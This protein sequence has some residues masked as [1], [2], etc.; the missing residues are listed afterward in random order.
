MGFVMRIPQIVRWTRPDVFSRLLYVAF[1]MCPWTRGRTSFSVMSVENMS[2]LLFQSGAWYFVWFQLTC[3]GISWHILHKIFKY[4]ATCIFVNKHV[5]QREIS[6]P[7]NALTWHHAFVRNAER[8]EQRQSSWHC[9]NCSVVYLYIIP[10][11]FIAQ[12]PPPRFAK[13]VK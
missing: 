10:P 1:L 6:R 7:L 11:Y 13:Q 3:N 8:Q 12:Q 2:A 4:P 9:P 5:L